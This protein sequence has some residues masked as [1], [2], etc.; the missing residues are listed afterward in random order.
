[1]RSCT[2]D[3]LGQDGG[4]VM[5]PACRRVMTGIRFRGGFGSREDDGPALDGRLF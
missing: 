3:G 5:E 1:M 4:L 2:W